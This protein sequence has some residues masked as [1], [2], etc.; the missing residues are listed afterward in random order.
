MFALIT[1]QQAQYPGFLIDREQWRYPWRGVIEMWALLA[2]LVGVLHVI[3]RPA[4]FQHS[5]G[6]LLG[7]LL[8]ATVLLLGLG[9]A[10]LATDMPGY[11]YV[12]AWFSIVT[13][14]GMLTLALVEVVGALWRR[15]R[16]A[17]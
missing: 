14:V 16:H 2:I 10:S 7:A 4:T 17:A 3:L 13:M 11:Y 15:R 1:L 8:Y 12:P 5:W 6:R 9:P